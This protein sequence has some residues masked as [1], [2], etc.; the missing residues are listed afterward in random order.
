MTAQFRVLPWA[1]AYTEARLR[2][3]TCVYSTV[4]TAER[5]AAFQWVGPLVDTDWA[6]FAL[7][8]RTIDSGSL[9]ALAGLR[10]GSYREDAVGRFVESHGIPVL[11][12]ATD[13]E[14]AL[15]LEAGLIDVWVTGEATARHVAGNA[16]VPIKRLFS[17]HRAN[18]YLACHPGVPGSL[19]SRLQAALDRLRNPD[20]HESHSRQTLDGEA[21]R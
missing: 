8:D 5:E 20:H 7:E 11:L 21:Q 3:D 19:L 6:A 16:G 1:R 18:M 2:E 13:R 9:E 12:T 15:R 4:R 17:F 14:N 10:V